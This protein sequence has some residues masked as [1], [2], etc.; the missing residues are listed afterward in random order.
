MSTLCE[1]QNG[2]C[3]VQLFEDGTKIRT[4]EGEPSPLFPESIDVKITNWCDKGCPWCHEKSTK[5]GK[6]AKTTD[7]VLFI[8]SLP[9]GVELAIGGGDPLSYPNIDGIIDYATQCGLIC[10]LTVNSAHIKRHAQLIHKLRA[11]GLK[12]LGISIEKPYLE[13]VDLVADNNTVLHVI[14]GI[15]PLSFLLKFTQKKILILGYKKYGFGKINYEKHNN[16]INF[17]LGCWKYWLPTIIKRSNNIY[18]FDN[19]AI[20]QL[21]VKNFLDP[22]YFQQFYMGDDGQ[23]TMYVDLVKMEYAKSSTSLERFSI[24]GLGI[25]EMFQQ[26]RKL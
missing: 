23:F 22:Q 7:I 25:E 15:T 10:N 4:Y 16:D 18:S 21:G 2:N 13:D 5:F 9:K 24:G 12:G 11:L 1:Y 3:L 6:H 26:I 17:Q 20:E 19:L 8:D 14:A